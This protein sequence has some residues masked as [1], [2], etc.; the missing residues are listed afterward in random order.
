MPAT[1]RIDDIVEA[2]EMQ[3]DEYPSFVDLDTGKVE[4]VSRDTLRAVE[5]SKEDEEPDAPG[6][7]DDEWERQA[8]PVHGKFQRT[9]NP[10]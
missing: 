2:L 3:F 9:P 1:V 5:E 10:V 8:D 7:E 4:T 6:E